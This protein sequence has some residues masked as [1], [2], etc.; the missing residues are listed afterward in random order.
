[1]SLPAGV[2]VERTM[3]TFWFRDAMALTREEAA[4]TSPAE[5][6]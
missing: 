5:T 4:T 6:A 1:M 2:V 3:L